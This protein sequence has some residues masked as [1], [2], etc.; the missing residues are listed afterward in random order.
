MM[1]YLF[2]ILLSVV[3]FGSVGFAEESVLP[4]EKLDKPDEQFKSALESIG[5]IA[6]EQEPEPQSEDKATEAV[7]DEDR[8]VAGF[9]AAQTAFRQANEAA[10]P[11]QA[12]A[13]YTKA[14]LN[15]EKII[16]LGN[17]SRADLYYNLANAYLLKEDV[18]RAILN[19]KRAE[20]LDPANA[21]I[22]KNLTFART[23]RI[24]A[25]S[26]KTQQRVLKTLFFW[27]YDFSIGARFVVA[28]ICFSVL[29][30]MLTIVVWRG[31]STCIIV[32]CVLTVMLL[33]AF[34][35]SVGVETF[36]K[37]RAKSGVIIS[38]SVIARQGDGTN[39]SPSFKDPL[40]AGTEF[41]LLE[42]RPGWFKI[43]LSDG[44]E[45]WI[46]TNSAELI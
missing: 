29:F 9:Q 28:C 43:Q 1:R 14:I 30:I 39:Y 33:T 18:G 10:T 45:G 27:H 40:H 12:K 25:V 3:M 13:L 38:P 46:T 31:R 36:T 17:L 20:K 19:Y 42:T 41:D 26:V 23:K 24:D 16:D 37:A 34:A 7:S 44:S 11:D 2:A 21:D 5:K 4:L 15:Y 6:D 22:L 32:I 8:I 35:G